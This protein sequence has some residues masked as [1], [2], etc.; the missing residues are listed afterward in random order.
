MDLS[1]VIPVYNESE[2]IPVLYREIKESLSGL[3]MEYEIIYVDDG[4]TDDTAKMLNDICRQ[5]KNV[6]IVGFTCNFGLSVAISVGFKFCRGRVVITMDGDC[7]HSPS[8]IS[9]FIK[10]I[11]KGFDIVCG[12]RKARARKFDRHFISVFGNMLARMVF[13]VPVH[14]FSTTFKAYRKE[15]LG[16]LVIFKGGHRFIPV[17]AKMKK[18]S[19]GEVI[20][21][22]RNRLHGSS[23]FNSWRLS[24]IVKDAIWLKLCQLAML[25]GRGVN[26]KEASFSIKYTVN[27][28]KSRF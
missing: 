26:F 15:A 16:R 11:E 25:L 27:V 24:K 17:L 10:E 12:Y 22:H 8:D 5:D 20:I 14:D 13:N 21:T 19:L 3:G 2:N 9:R 6:S 1:L 23:K 18:M 4:S 7:E 28:I